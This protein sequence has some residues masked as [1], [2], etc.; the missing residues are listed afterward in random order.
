MTVVHGGWLKLS[1]GLM[2]LTKGEWPPRVAWLL[3]EPKYQVEIWGH[4]I[5][6]VSIPVF[7]SRW[8][9]RSTLLHLFS[10]SSSLRCSL[11]QETRLVGSS[12]IQYSWREDKTR[13]GFRQQH[14]TQ[15]NSHLCSFCFYDAC[16][17]TSESSK[18]AT[19]TSIFTRFLEISRAK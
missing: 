7:L 8:R 18:P 16:L 14:S 9:S 11:R 2:W 19:R 17:N 13:L 10:N 4:K 1:Y 5:L 6:P 3:N 15:G 12:S